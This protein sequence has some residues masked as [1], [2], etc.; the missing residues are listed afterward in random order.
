MYL[1]VD[2]L[3]AEL[4]AD[5]WLTS[6]V[7]IAAIDQPKTSIASVIEIQYAMEDDWDRERLATVHESITAAGIETVPLTSDEAAAA[8]DL[9][10]RY[11]AVNVFDAVHLGTAA[12]LDERIVSTDTLYPRIEEVDH[13]DPRDV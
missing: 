12:V 11:D 7:E 2:V 6:A 9:R 3:L 5:D 10:V 13:V 1:D 4:K 8:A